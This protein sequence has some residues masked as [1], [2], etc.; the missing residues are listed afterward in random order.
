MNNSFDCTSMWH[1]I[2]TMCMTVL[3]VQ[4]AKFI[5]LKNGLNYA[6]LANVM[7][8]SKQTYICY[9][10]KASYELPLP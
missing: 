2:L 9:I 1:I 5:N 3:A 6:S 4:A 10:I 7:L 8:V